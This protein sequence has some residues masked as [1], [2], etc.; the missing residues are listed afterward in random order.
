MIGVNLSG[1]EF[2]GAGK[3]YGTDYEYPGEVDLD[4][5]QSKG[6]ELIRLPFKWERMQTTPGGALNADELGRMKA[7]LAD[8]EAHG[9]Q[10]ILDLH[11]YGRFGTKIVGSAEL[12]ASQ[13]ADFWKKLAVEL[14]DFPAVAGFDLMNEPHDMGAT[15]WPATVQTVVN[16]IRSVDM[17]TTI[18]VEGNGWAS[19]SQ[20][21]KH[22][23]NLII[24]DPAGKIV[25]EAHL[26]FDKDN[27]GTYKGSYDQEGANPN[28]G[29][30]RLQPF[31][32][33]LA[34]NNLK[35]FIG[36][37]NAP[38]NDPR[39]VTVLDNTIAAMNAA[40]VSGTLWGGGSRWQADYSMSLRQADGADSAQMALVA[41]KYLVPPATPSI[42]GTNGANTLFGTEFAD[43]IKAYKGNDVIHGSGGADKIDGGIGTDTIT[44]QASA[45]G[46]DVD[47]TR[48]TQLGG[49]AEGDRF[50]Y[51]ESITGSSFA[52][53][54]MGDERGNTLL[55]GGGDDIVEGR[56]GADTLDGGA[57]NDQ[58]YGGADKDAIFG[59]DGDDRIEGGAAAD[60]I[61]GGAGRD[62]FVYSAYSDSNKS[63]ADTITDLT[64]LDVIDLSRVDANSKVAGDQAFSI[65]SAFSKRAGEMTVT[66]DA[67]K[68]VTSLA[69]DVNA[70]GQADMLILLG[71]DHRG[72][73]GFVL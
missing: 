2:G 72:F 65:V 51:I 50:T 10:V 58:I 5:Y 64:A 73:T 32:D 13:L 61:T 39:W 69:M 56:A 43:N 47:L 25:Y 57:G 41:Q 62:V 52:D 59:G 45:V 1:A 54:I 53:L 63:G 30:Q 24:N 35:G 22:N 28:I 17:D 26:Y 55:G 31:L 60:Q 37:F 66:Y 11:N 46:V 8:A 9:M 44:Y 16:A 38:S 12:P 15:D 3:T 33:W 67:T 49:F 68:K 34:A 70:D 48:L 71:G 4:Y 7:F 14:K 42:L 40:G 36:E 21:L 18:Y 19:A 6:V 20:W 27:S 29:V 23:A